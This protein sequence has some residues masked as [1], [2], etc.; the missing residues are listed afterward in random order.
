MRTCVL[1]LV[2]TVPLCSAVNLGEAGANKPGRRTNDE[3]DF[4]SQVHAT[5]GIEVSED[6]TRHAYN[7]QDAIEINGLRQLLQN[8]CLYTQ[9]THDDS[10]SGRCMS[11]MICGAS[12]STG[13]ARLP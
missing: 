3:S 6:K 12:S 9:R 4:Q 7:L 1:C 10:L 13:N 8:T 11:K 5:P 2:R